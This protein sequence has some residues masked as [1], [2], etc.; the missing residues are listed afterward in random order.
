MDRG[1]ALVGKGLRQKQARPGPS[2]LLCRR[3]T[4]RRALRRRDQDGLRPIFSQSLQPGTGRIVGQDHHAPQPQRGAQHGQGDPLIARADLQD[5]IALLQPALPQRV[6]QD[7][8]HG[9]V[10]DAAA[11]VHAL[12]L[13][14]D[15]GHAAMGLRKPGQPEQGCVADEFRYIV[16]KFRHFF[17][18]LPESFW[19]KTRKAESALLF[20]TKSHKSF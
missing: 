5:R 10:L 20:S 9:P 18:L 15:R 11:G 7:A 16:Q 8:Q 13:G 4:A 14:Q 1:V 17:V 2:Q 6:P 3:L 19:P 12:Q